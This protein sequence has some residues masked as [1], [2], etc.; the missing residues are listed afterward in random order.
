V[1]A[2]AFYDQ[3][4]MGYDPVVA[5]PR[6]GAIAEWMIGEYLPDLSLGEGGEFALTLHEWKSGDYAVQVHA[7]TDA[8]GSLEA[9]LATGAL[10]WLESAPW[11]DEP[12][13][14]VRACLVEH[15]LT[16]RSREG[17]LA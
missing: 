1:T 9:V 6:D 12:R 3:E 14:H 15:G 2:L 4:R 8:M 17:T 10:R 7:F 16:D 5:E 11:G 13:E